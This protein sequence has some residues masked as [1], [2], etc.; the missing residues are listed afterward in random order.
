MFIE[1]FIW[2]NTEFFLNPLSITIMTKTNILLLTSL[3]FILGFPYLS[4][5]G[6]NDTVEGY[7]KPRICITGRHRCILKRFA[8]VKYWCLKTAHQNILDSRRTTS[9][10]KKTYREK[11]G[12]CEKILPIIDE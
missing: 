12:H 1:F 3:F 7:K 4:F 9:P 6:T 2:K 11:L 5:A 10:I 8:N